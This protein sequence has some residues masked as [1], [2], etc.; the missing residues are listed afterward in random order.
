MCSSDLGTADKVETLY[1]GWGTFDTHAVINNLRWGPDGWIYGAVGYTRGRVKSGDGSKD[2]GDIAAGIYRF[3]P[4][5]SML[6]QIA[7]GGCNTWGCEVAPDGEIVFT[8]ATC[9]EPICHVVIPEKALA[10]GQVGGLKS[11]LNIIEENKIYPAFDEKRQPY[12]QIDWVGAWTAAAGATIYD[13][14]DRKST[15][16]NSS[17]T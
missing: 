13:G 2:F 7:A 17:H 1:T 15:R 14:G 3:R 12:V 4:D 11:F 9:G 6:E 16:L 5:G 8:T 10:R